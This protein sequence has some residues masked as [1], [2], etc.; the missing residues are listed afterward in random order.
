MTLSYFLDVLLFFQNVKF[1]SRKI[2]LFHDVRLCHVL[3][4]Y[5]LLPSE[6]YKY[7]LV[8]DWM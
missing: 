8:R 4:D 7:E 2:P 5:S 3:H 6:K 1:C